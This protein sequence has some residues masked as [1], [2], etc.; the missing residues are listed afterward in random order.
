MSNVWSLID[1]F[2]Q[3][4]CDGVAM[5]AWVTWAPNPQTPLG[6]LWGARGRLGYGGHLDHQGVGLVADLHIPINP[7]WW[8]YYEMRLIV[9]QRFYVGGEPTHFDTRFNISINSETGPD[10]EYRNAVP[11]APGTFFLAGDEDGRFG[12]TV[13]F[14]PVL[15]HSLVAYQNVI[16]EVP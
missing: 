1:P 2:Y 13:R 16:R 15:A 11:I 6:R 5:D 9:D 7:D 14:A 10:S 4:M 8:F 12:A 3:D